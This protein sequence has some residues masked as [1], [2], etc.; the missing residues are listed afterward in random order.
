M[1]WENDFRF[2][3]LSSLA[4]RSSVYVGGMLGW[5]LCGFVGWR[6]SL[7]GQAGMSWSQALGMPRYTCFLSKSYG[8]KYPFPVACWLSLLDFLQTFPPPHTYP[9]YYGLHPGVHQQL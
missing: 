2:P 3:D 7:L 6:K 4:G 1:T 9:A 5:N 8:F